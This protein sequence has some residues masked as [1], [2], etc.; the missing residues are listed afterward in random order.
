MALRLN[1]DPPPMIED[2]PAYVWQCADPYCLY[3]EHPIP[4]PEYNWCYWGIPAQ[5]LEDLWEDDP[6]AARQFQDMKEEYPR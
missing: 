5:E 2:G 3:F 4:A 6:L 1:G